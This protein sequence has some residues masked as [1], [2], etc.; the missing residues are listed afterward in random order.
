MEPANFPPENLQEQVQVPANLP[1]KVQYLEN[2]LFDLKM[3]QY[4]NRPTLLNLI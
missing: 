2:E 1:K 4:K 3:L